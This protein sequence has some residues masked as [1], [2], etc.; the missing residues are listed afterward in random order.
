MD[1]LRAQ[2]SKTFSMANMDTT[3]HSYL[4]T[5]LEARAGQSLQAAAGAS[6]SHG[7]PRFAS[8]STAWTK[9]GATE[10]RNLRHL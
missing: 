7:T 8:S 1:S 10:G 5:E 6:V 9:L 3:T 2:S 4:H